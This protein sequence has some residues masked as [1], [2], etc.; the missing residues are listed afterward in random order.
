MIFKIK[1]QLLYGV[2]TLYLGQTLVN[3]EEEGSPFVYFLG[4][5]EGKKYDCF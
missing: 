2:G 1:P 4:G 5:L 3:L